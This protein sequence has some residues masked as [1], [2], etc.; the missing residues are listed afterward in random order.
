MFQI[1]S[2]IYNR[3]VITSVS[4][5]EFINMMKN[6]DFLRKSQVDLAR[7]IYKESEL[8]KED[9]SYVSIKNSLSC[10]T[11]FNVF[12]GSV[13]NDNIVNKTGFMY[14][15]AD[16]INNLDLSNFN[17]VVAYWKSLSNDGYGIL[18][19]CSNMLEE[20][21]E[22]VKEISK[23]LGIKLDNNAVSKDRLNAIGYDEKIYY[24]SEY[25]D[26]IFNNNEKVSSS[27]INTKSSNRLRVDDTKYQEEVGKL[28]FSNLREIED[29]YDFEGKDFAIL[30]E[31]IEYAEVFV[32]KNIFEGNRNN[33]MFIICS[34]IRGLNSWISQESL[35]RVCKTI[36]EDKFKPQINLSELNDI[37]RKVYENKNP[38]VILNKTRRVL[39]NPKS[40]LSREDK[41]FI[42]G[43]EMGKFK[44]NI[45]TNKILECI[46]DWD[47]KTNGKISF[48]KISNNSKLGI[49]TIKRR[50][51]IIKPIIQKLNKEMFGN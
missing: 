10:I 7:K 13:R 51:N 37:V 1:V 4:L 49:A 17:F 18:I 5:D 23:V 26:Y 32:A 39:Y 16:H 19:K 6:P 25:V 30:E 31:K 36:N 15:D 46:N 20:P 24:N 22:N 14:L 45:T 43:S 8:G 48:E 47:F 44:K 27:N 3:N 50:S 29:N 12:N 28:R 35:F 2:N 42:T 34:Q 40:G 33:S 38:I 9:P 21:L 41:K 11:F